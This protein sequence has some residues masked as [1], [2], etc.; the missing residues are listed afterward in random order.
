MDKMFEIANNRQKDEI[1]IEC[2]SSKNQFTIKSQVISKNL[3]LF[4][5]FNSF[6]KSVII[7]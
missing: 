1:I 2:E 7:K 5:I 6:F 3:K 4:F